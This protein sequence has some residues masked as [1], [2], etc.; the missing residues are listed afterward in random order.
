MQRSLEIPLRGDPKAAPWEQ[1]EILKRK[2][3]Q[4]YF[5]PSRIPI[6]SAIFSPNRQIRVF[7]GAEPMSK[8]I[9]G[10]TAVK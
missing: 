10:K 3:K 4:A 8:N 5:C 6:I 1:W 9:I 7:C 2:N